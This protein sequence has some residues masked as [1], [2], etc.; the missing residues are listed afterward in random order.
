MDPLRDVLTRI[1]NN[2]EPLISKEDPSTIYIEQSTIGQGSSGTVTVAIDKRTNEKVAIKKM[3]LSHGVNQLDTLESEIYIMKHCKHPNIVNYVD[4]YIVGNS[5]WCVMEYMD[6]GDLT[7]VIR[8]CQ[9]RYKEPQIAALLKEVFFFFFILQ[10][11]I[12]MRLLLLLLLLLLYTYY[13]LIVII[14]YYFSI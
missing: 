3:I 13:A 1:I 5:L 11:I 7:E 2:S 10:I 12:I 4:S 14:Y 8:I 9:R 6:G